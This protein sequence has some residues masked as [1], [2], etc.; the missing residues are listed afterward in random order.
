V[1]SYCFDYSVDATGLCQDLLK[2]IVSETE[3]CI[4]TAHNY[5]I[6]DI[7]LANFGIR[8]NQVQTRS[9]NKKLQ[10]HKQFDLIK[11]MARNNTQSHDN[12]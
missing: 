8:L 4:K 2:H 1:V 5:A 6:K 12:H 3:K 10:Q 9:K 7:K 11:Y